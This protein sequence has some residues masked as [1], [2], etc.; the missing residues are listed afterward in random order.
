MIEIAIS[1]FKATWLAVLERVRRTGEPVLVTRRGVP[2]AEIK[3]PQPPPLAT[4][5]LG[6]MAGTVEVV[7]HMLATPE[8]YLVPLHA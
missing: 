3:L 5:W 7:G 4:S 1:E 8:W 6:S 2:I